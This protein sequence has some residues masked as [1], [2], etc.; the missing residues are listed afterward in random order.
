VQR[1]HYPETLHP[2]VDSEALVG[3]VGNLHWIGNPPVS[4]E[5]TASSSMVSVARDASEGIV[6]RSC[7]R[8]FASEGVRNGGKPAATALGGFSTLSLCGRAK[9]SG[10]WNYSG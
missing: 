5:R 3:Q 6:F 9:V 2:G 10:K 1:S 4:V 7:E 8:F